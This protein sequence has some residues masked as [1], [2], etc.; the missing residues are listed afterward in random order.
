MPPL[1]DF[2]VDRSAEVPIGVQ[3][4]WALR[5]R[6]G[7]GRLAPGLRLPGLRDLAESLAINANTVR[8]VY[9]R[10]EQEGLLETRQGSG[11]FVAGGASS[12]RPQ[13]SAIAAGAA[14]E[15]LRS[16]VDP[17]EVAAALYVDAGQRRRA[18]LHSDTEM[19]RRVRLR[20]QI[21]ALEQTL[22]ELEA[23]YPSLARRITR[24]GLRSSHAHASSTARLPSAADLEQIRLT[25]V[26]R[27]TCMQSLIDGIEDG[28]EHVQQADQTVAQ[29]PVAAPG[30]GRGQASRTAHKAPKSRSRP[31]TANT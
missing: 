24:R 22:S 12:T 4:A 13:A 7:D 2:A 17:R 10:L 1:A 3:L 19:P 30:S 20:S 27:L 21:A 29:A 23:E 28:G 16:G 8:A 14:R 9:A 11:T 6:V 25:L 5:A 18:S 31:A 26:R 15:A